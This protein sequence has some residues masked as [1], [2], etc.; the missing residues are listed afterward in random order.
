[1]ACALISIAFASSNTASTVPPR[2]AG[3]DSVRL[4][5]VTGAFVVVAVS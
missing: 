2:P 3:E 5:V 4:A 1:M